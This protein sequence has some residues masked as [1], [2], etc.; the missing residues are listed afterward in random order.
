MHNCRRSE[1]TED[2]NKLTQLEVALAVLFAITATLL[3]A[4]LIWY[5]CREPEAPNTQ[6]IIE[7]RIE[8]V[9]TP[10]PVPM[11]QAPVMHQAPVMQAQMVQQ[12][13]M[14]MMGTMQA[15]IM[16]SMPGG[17]MR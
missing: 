14:Q 4:A 12:A 15:P 10:V 17:I 5:F 11:M 1:H 16:G 6:T 9:Q 2:P 13:P 7:K 3:I 8:H